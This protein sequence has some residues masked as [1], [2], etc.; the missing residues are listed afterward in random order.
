LTAAVDVVAQFG[1]PDQEERLLVIAWVAEVRD[2][3]VAS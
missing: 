3:R 1:L 2:G